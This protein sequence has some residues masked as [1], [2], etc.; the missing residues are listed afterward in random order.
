MSLTKFSLSGRRVWV[1]GHQGMVG[2]A[3]LRL[4][5]KSPCELLTVDRSQLDLRRQAKVEE[6]MRDQKPEVVI[7]AAAT[8]GGI[9]ANESRA[10]E[11]LYDNLTIETNIV[12]ASYG[13]GVQKL[14]LLGSTCI[15]PRAAAQ[16]MTEDALLTGPLEPT[17]EWYAIAKIA[18]IKLCDA[19]RKQFGCNFISA[20]PTNLYGPQDNF[21]LDSAHVLPAL[22]RKIHEAKQ[23][24]SKEVEIWGTGNPLREFLHV[25]DLASAL[26]FLVENYNEAGHINIGSGEEVSINGLAKMLR[27]VIGY[28]GE[29][30]YLTNKPDGTPRKL[31]DTAKLARLGWQPKISLQEGIRKAYRWYVDSGG[32]S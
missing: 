9:A 16:P 20:Q 17:N 31:V 27:E 18:G 21:D 1:A 3:L 32:A 14:L 15:Y 4:M 28:R 8:V 30:R 6:W 25:D 12:H 11:F 24:Q 23:S 7:I 13:I 2:A 29:F 5:R 10:A 26:L 22:M 19:F